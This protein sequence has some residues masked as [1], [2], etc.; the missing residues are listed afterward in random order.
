MTGKC[1]K[2]NG[3]AERDRTADLLNAIYFQPTLICY[4]ILANNLSMFEKQYFRG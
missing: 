3:G 4:T 2:I 1:L